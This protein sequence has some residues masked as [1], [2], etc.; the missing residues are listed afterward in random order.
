M[1]MPYDFIKCTHCDFIGFD[2]VLWGRRDY[3][4]S[5]GQRM[6]VD[7]QMG[8][9]HA[10][11]DVTA[12]EDL[13]DVEAKGTISEANTELATLK[14]PGLIATLQRKF[15]YGPQ[16]IEHWQEKIQVAE[17]RLSFLRSRQ[18]P[19]RCLICSSTHVEPIY[20]ESE[21][22]LHVMSR[23]VHFM[24]PN[25]G[26][27]LF[28]ENSNCWEAGLPMARTYSANGVFQGVENPA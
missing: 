11:D 13:S 8:W 27:N 21:R 17:A 15:N 16:Q 12:I 20:P 26:G 1:S 23:R 19:I 9:C 10:C 6:R 22:G 14:R 18:D 3:L 5:D 2:R 24:H 25:C 4:L 7:R 28:R